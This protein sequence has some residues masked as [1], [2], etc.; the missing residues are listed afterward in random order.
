VLLIAHSSGIED[1]ALLLSRAAALEEKFPTGA[2]ATLEFS[3]AWRELAVGR[4]S[5]VDFVTPRGHRGRHPAT[6]TGALT[7]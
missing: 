5:L 2:P 6:W 7:P 3:G 1:L 4:A